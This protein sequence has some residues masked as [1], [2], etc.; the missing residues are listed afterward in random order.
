MAGIELGQVVCVVVTIWAAGRGSS[1]FD[2]PS[3]CNII[4]SVDFSLDSNGLKGAGG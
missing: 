3:H 1:D 2:C 4:V